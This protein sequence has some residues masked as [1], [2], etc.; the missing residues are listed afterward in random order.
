M[1]E[2]YSSI[3]DCLAQVPELNHID[4]EGSQELSNYPAAY[5]Q[6]SNVPWEELSSGVNQAEATFTVRIKVKP[7]H[8][9]AKDSPALTDLKNDMAFIRDVRRY[10]RAWGDDWVQN[11]VITGDNLRRTKDG[12]YEEVISCRCLVVEED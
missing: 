4:I 1:I 3:A 8:R 7:Y 12:I 5:I 9:S 10:L 11:V 6:V 2:I